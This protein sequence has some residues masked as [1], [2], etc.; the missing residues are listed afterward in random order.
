MLI[1]VAYFVPG[2]RGTR[3]LT[4][5]ATRGVRVRVLTNSLA[6]T[7]VVAVHSGYARYREALVAGGVELHEYLPESIRPAP[8]KHRM[9]L[10]A[11][12]STLHAKVA[13]YDRRHLWIGSANQDARSAR[14]N[15]ET[16]VMI[17]SPELATRVADSLER[18]LSPTQS[19]RLELAY[20]QSTGRNHLKWRAE[21]AGR[22]VVFDR[23][24]DAPL[25]RHL[26]AGFYSLIPGLEDLL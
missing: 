20:D 10:G 3:L 12:A 2:S 7:D 5:L 13:I 23:E 19:W 6:S 24:P 16:G 4:D 22:S 1:A 21:R 8:A 26:G 25:L 11:S 14:L 9:R 15:T 18:D 17:D